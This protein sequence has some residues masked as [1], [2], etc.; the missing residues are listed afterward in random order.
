MEPYPN[1]RDLERLSGI[2]WGELT[3]LEPR[4]DELLWR[5]RR[6]CAQCRLPSDVR[7]VFAPVRDHLVELVGFAGKNRR[8]PVLGSPGAY[9]VAYW[10]LYDAVVGLLPGRAGGTEEALEKRRGET[11]AETCPT[12]SAATALARA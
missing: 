4:L 11:S 1:F 2:T 3:A 8:H 9:A 7:R 10:R 6:A 12:A 5:A